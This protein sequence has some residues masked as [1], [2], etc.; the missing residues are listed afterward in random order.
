MDIA[1]L[2]LAQYLADRFSL[3]LVT[4][5]TEGT[6]QSHKS[7]KINWVARPLNMHLLGTPILDWTGRRVAKQL[8]REGKI[9]VVVNGGN[10]V[11]PGSINWIHYVHAAY[12]PQSRGRGLRSIKAKLHRW[13][14]L[15]NERTAVHQSNLIICNSELSARHM[16]ELLKVPQSKVKVIYYG[17]DSHRFKPASLEERAA[18]RQRLGWQQDQQYILFIGAMGDQRKG[19]DKVATAI[20]RLHNTA[21]WNAKVIVVGSGTQIAHWKEHFARLGMS[22]SVEFLGFRKDVPDLLRAAD[23][24]VAPTR[25]EAYGLGVHE[26]I[27]CGLPAFVSRQSGVAERFPDPLA[28]QMLIDDPNDAEELVQKLLN[29]RQNIDYYQTKVLEL[30]TI[31]RQRTWTHMAEQF[32]DTV[33]ESDRA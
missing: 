2:R 14:S 6:L 23:A 11:V 26:A 8:S 10:C 4:H 20:E 13:H 16:I 9:H 24:L 17:I 32:V 5:R 1:N 30:S 7:V 25:Y 28:S 31:L 18:L 27:C 12:S 21:R 22:E 15:R 3:H 19:F 33:F 29:W